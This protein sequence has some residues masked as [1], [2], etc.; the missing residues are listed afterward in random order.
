M[1][2]G[3][4][5]TVRFRSPLRWRQAHFISCHGNLFL[6]G[7]GPDSGTRTSS[8]PLLVPGFRRGEQIYFPSLWAGSQK[9]PGV[10]PKCWVTYSLFCSGDASSW[11]GSRAA[12]AGGWAPGTA[13]GVRWAGGRRGTPAQVSCPPYLLP[14]A[15]GKEKLAP[16]T[17]S[18]VGGLRGCFPD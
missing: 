14:E 11:R 18:T 4:V 7:H 6:A 15:G 2:P 3:L 1:A 10:S 12:G 5:F 16:Q 13:W 8:A 9:N 17:R